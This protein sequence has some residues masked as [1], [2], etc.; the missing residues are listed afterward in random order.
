VEAASPS[1]FRASREGEILKSYEET[2]HILEAFD[3]TQSYRATA[4]LT[5][6]DH[7]T[8]ARLVAARDAGVLRIEPAPRDR[9]TDPWLE[10]I[11]EW[12]E[13]SRGRVRGDIAHERLLALGYKGSERTTRRAVRAAKKRRH[14]GHGRVYRPWIVEPGMW[15]Q[16]DFGDGPGPLPFLGD[17]GC[18]G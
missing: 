17:N 6:C 11:E 4:Q 1:G 12:V 13:H 14:L 8:V 9:V 3:L 15:F 16:W 18:N 5:G 10:K 7:H 2:M